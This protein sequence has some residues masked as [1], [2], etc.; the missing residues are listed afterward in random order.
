MNLL[1]LISPKSNWFQQFNASFLS[2]LFCSISLDQA[3]KIKKIV[4]EH[5]TCLSILSIDYRES[6]TPMASWAPTITQRTC[7]SIYN[8]M[9]R[10][11][12]FLF[13][14]ALSRSSDC[15][16]QGMTEGPTPLSPLLASIAES[17]DLDNLWILIM[18]PLSHSRR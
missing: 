3:I 9:S 11:I 4:T 16:E 6:S 17:F 18:I 14:Y 12:L 1:F 13:L 15:I 10:F 7:E 5:C 2:L 8:L